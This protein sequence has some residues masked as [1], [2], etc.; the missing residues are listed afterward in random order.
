MKYNCERKGR[1]RQAVPFGLE[2]VAIAFSLACA[3]IASASPVV[4]TIDYGWT[5][6][7]FAGQ[8]VRAVVIDPTN[9][10][11]LYAA[12]FGQGV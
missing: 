8:T 6:L 12:V 4:A 11:R 10:A 7:G 3:A 2:L 5:Q 1:V 9:P